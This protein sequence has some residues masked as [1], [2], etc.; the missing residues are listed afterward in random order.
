MAET[1]CRRRSAPHRNAANAA[2][3]SRT[4]S[5]R[6]AVRSIP[7]TAA[8]SSIEVARALGQGRRLRRIRGPV[9][10]E[11][12]DLLAVHRGV[13]R[14]GLALHPVDGGEQLP[15]DARA[16]GDVAVEVLAAGQRRLGGGEERGASPRAGAAPGTGRARW[17]P[18]AR[19]TRAV[20]TIPVLVATPG[21]WALPRRAAA[22]APARAGR[23]CPAG[24]AAARRGRC[25]R[26]R[27]RRR[28][29]RGAGVTGGGRAAGRRRPGRGAQRAAAGRRRAAGASGPGETRPGC[30]RRPPR[31]RRCP[32][33][34]RHGGPDGAS[35]GAA[36]PGTARA[37][38]PG[39]R[40]W[41]GP[42][43]GPPRRPP[44]RASAS[45]RRGRVAAGAACA[46]AGA[47]DGVRGRRCGR[48]RPVADAGRRAPR[49]SNWYRLYSFISA[50]RFAP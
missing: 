26:R 36:T 21:T 14:V 50:I 34:R 5:R 23:G 38:S 18:V 39:A 9:G 13:A 24:R 3:S 48:R 28:G 42:G 16:G 37:R 4:D 44:G 45:P 33:C 22:A 46:V 19:V 15:A 40:P 32:R 12:A 41:R 30:A 20:V 10:V 2:A 6:R 7:Y 17:P 27:R 47:A 8:A 29:D 11:R 49:L 25:G 1:P 35:A 31:L 43:A